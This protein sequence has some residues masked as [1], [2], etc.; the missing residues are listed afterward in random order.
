MNKLT[1]TAKSKKAIPEL[2]KFEDLA[3][4][5]N[6]YKDEKGIEKDNQLDFEM[7]VPYPIE[8][9]EERESMKKILALKQKGKE[10][11]ANKL[12]ILHK[13][14]YGNSKF[15]YYDWHCSNWGTKWN[16]CYAKPPIK[17]DNKLTYNFDTAWGPPLPVII[18]MS[19]LFPNLIVNLKYD[20]PGMCFKGTLECKNGKIIKDVYKD[21]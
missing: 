13:L 1:I 5:K 4:T 8:V 15:N 11:E 14:T 7:F 17:K 19:I 16:S 10:A 9:N 12:E 21:Y 6:Y 20:E 18:A 2:K 3:L